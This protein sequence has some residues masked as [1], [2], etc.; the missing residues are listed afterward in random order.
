MQE[1]SNTNAFLESGEASLVQALVL[2]Q[3]GFK[4]INSW[5]SSSPPPANTA[6]ITLFL[7]FFHSLFLFPVY[8]LKS[9]IQADEREGVD[10][11]KILRKGK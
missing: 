9:A 3:G 1:I 6:I 11:A 2:V 7:S 10:G 4:K 8:Q 5:P